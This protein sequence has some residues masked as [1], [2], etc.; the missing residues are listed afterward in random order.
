M[1]VAEQTPTSSGSSETLPQ[2][3][4]E[5]IGK[6]KIETITAPVANC[7]ECF[8]SLVVVAVHHVPASGESYWDLVCPIHRTRF[9]VLV[10]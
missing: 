7:P 1:S 5:F 6:H 3:V 4:A 8:R 10:E 2:E 9:G